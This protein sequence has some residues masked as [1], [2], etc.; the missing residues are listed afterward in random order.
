MIKLK[1][2]SGNII[3]LDLFKSTDLSPDI[4]SK[5]GFKYNP[6]YKSDN[7]KSGIYFGTNLKQVKR[8]GKYLYKASVDIEDSKLYQIEESNYN[9]LVKQGKTTDEYVQ[10]NGYEAVVIWDVI[11]SGNKAGSEVILYY[12]KKQIKDIQ[13]IGENID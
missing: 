4:I 12:P 6:E 9:K 3:R 1:E 13:Y 10:K 8:F 11:Y 5:E 7:F 2:I